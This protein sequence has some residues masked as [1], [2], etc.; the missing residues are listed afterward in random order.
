MGDQRGYGGQIAVATSGE[1]YVVCHSCVPT[2]THGLDAVYVIGSNGKLSTF[3]GGNGPGYSGDG[4]SA[5]RA[6][7]GPPDGVAVDKTGNVYFSDAL[8]HVIR[9]VSAT[10]IITTVAGNGTPGYSGDGGPATRSQLNQPTKL[11]ADSSGNLFIIDSGNNRV[12][13]VTPDGIIRTVAGNGVDGDNGDGGP[14][15]AA[16]IDVADGPWTGLAV[17][18]TGDFFIAEG[19]MG[20][21]RKVSTSGT[22]TKVI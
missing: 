12:R 1:V 3:A 20:H 10:G 8:D 4:G 7:L 17:D 2:G 13:E 22:I 16:S 21:V 18:A 19:R 9:R 6:M 11:A 5:R 14:A 15:T